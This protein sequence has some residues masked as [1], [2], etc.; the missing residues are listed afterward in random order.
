[1]NTTDDSPEVTPEYFRGVAGHFASG[2]TVIS[3]VDDGALYGTTASAVSSLSLEPPMMLMCLNTSSTTHDAVMRAGVFGISILAADQGGL[4]YHF[5][6]R[7]G[8]KFAGID[9]TVRAAGVPVLDGAVARIVCEVAGTI[10]GGTHTV[11]LGRVLQ[12]STS[13][14]EPLAYYRGKL[15]RL[16]D[17]AERGIYE[18]VRTAVIA[19]RT[20]LGEPI[21]VDALARTVGGDP[22]QVVNALIKLSLE[23]VV[24]RD[25]RG[26]FRPK[27]I[28]AASVEE[29]Y[30]ARLS[31]EIG[32]LETRFS[33]LDDTTR[34][35]LVD[36]ADQIAKVRAGDADGLEEYLRLNVDYHVALVGISG[37]EQ[38]VETFRRL[39]AGTS[40]RQ[41]LTRDEWAQELDNG[42]ISVI[43][44]ALLRDDVEAAKA[45]LRRHAEYAK[46]LA[47]RVIERAGGAV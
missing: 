38:L 16:A 22:G 15:G 24:E 27:P 18:E 43:T 28:T 30:E 32:V 13:A 4:A 14:K 7:G 21:D 26:E 41:A 35:R 12:A 11:F 8:D 37:S 45:E 42:H 20:P 36:I 5:G 40:W 34:T 3:T 10:R 33:H 2:V 29:T 1:M 44:D 19:R 9:Y 47:R 25:E 23:D 39:S 17:S 46:Q 31:I 6:K